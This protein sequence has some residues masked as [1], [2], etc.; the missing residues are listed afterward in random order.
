MAEVE[1]TSPFQTLSQNSPFGAKP[2]QVNAPEP[3][4]QEQQ[5][6]AS[7]IQSD[8]QP[9]IELSDDE[10]ADQFLAGDDEAAADAFLGAE[11]APIEEPSIPVE[12]RAE[13]TLQDFKNQFKD[14]LTRT[15]LSFAVTDK[16]RSGLL[17]KIFGE[18]NVERQDGEFLVRD[19][20]TGK[21]RRI[22][23]SGFELINDVLDFS[24]EA[25]E[26][27]VALPFE[28]GGALAGGLAAGPA[29]V[30]VGIGA[31]R[32]ASTPAQIKVADAIGEFLGIERDPERS[33]ALEAAVGTA[34]NTA[35]P[36]AGAKLTSM[37]ANRKAAKEAAKEAKTVVLRKSS[38]EF[39]T[40]TNELKDAGLVQ[41]IPGTD[42][43]IVLWQLHPDAPGAL[44]MRKE[45]QDNPQV[46]NMLTKQGEAA[47]TVLRDMAEQVGDVSGKI[48][49]DLAKEITGI[50][51]KLR[52][53]EGEQLGKFRL[54]AKSNLGPNTKLPVT[55]EVSEGINSLAQG[56]GLGR[57]EAGKLVMPK[58]IDSLLGSMGIT[59]KEDF[60]SIA[61]AVIQLGNEGAE[62]LSL[63]Q[64]ERLVKVV[65]D[66][67]P[68]ARKIGGPVSGIYGKL[69]SDLRNSWNESVK[70]GLEKVPGAAE[71]FDKVRNK[72]TDILDT[73]NSLARSLNDELTSQAFVRKIILE[74]KTDKEAMKLA[75]NMLQK[76]HP[77]AWRKLTG[78][79]MANLMDKFTVENKATGFNSKGFLKELNSY[80]K[81]FTDQLFEGSGVKKEDFVKMLNFTKRLERTD[82]SVMSRDTQ[83]EI[84]QNVGLFAS[85]SPTLHFRAAMNLLRIGRNKNTDVL[86]RLQQEG[87]D[88]FLNRVPK[89]E[90]GRVRTLFS[91]MVAFGRANG[92]MSA[93]TRVE[94]RGGITEEIQNKKE[95]Q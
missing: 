23:Q 52:S 65:G 73:Q 34:L 63:N 93:T 5:D 89:S 14:S 40:I 68:G 12:P 24:R 38:Q 43:P 78:N 13:D 85:K 95:G 15:K 57:N 77:D 17:T 41:N 45:F 58:D 70:S 76:D 31:G 28:A 44:I 64:Y 51:K 11:A 74:G 86:K 35:V 6:F 47:N 39:E 66:R 7:S 19:K 54:Q 29:G 2:Q 9:Q 60:R 50:A 33:F 42:T 21:F 61:N 30:A 8:A 69:A 37:L 80:G 62:G 83:N 10:V 36:L 4:A 91:N 27:A 90:R 67:V 1:G 16:E 88:K 72:F 71:E 59:K 56:L 53:A 94:L 22:D 18:G 82:I 84:I 55:P 92:L 46:L 3:G 25:V 79:I 87:I 49:L 32:A 75:R 81:E 20:S 48:D 26:E